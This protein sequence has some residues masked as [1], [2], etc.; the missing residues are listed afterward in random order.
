VVIGYALLTRC[1]IGQ[2]PALC[3][4]PCAVVPEYQR[5]GAGTA[6]IRGALEAA[7]AQGEDTVVVLGHPDYYPRFGF[8]SASVYGIRLSIEVP[9]GAL[10]VLSLD[11]GR[12]PPD[13]TVHYA[14]PFGI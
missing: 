4:A 3:L 10:M 5:S 9:E 7:R 11:P 1:H 2:E 6:V 13:G 12:V 8:E 14:Q